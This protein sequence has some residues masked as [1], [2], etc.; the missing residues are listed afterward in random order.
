MPKKK[1]TGGSKNDAGKLRYDLIP[2][3]ALAALAFVYTIG[4]DKYED[5]N[6]EKGISFGRLIA[7]QERHVNNFKAGQNIDPKDGQHHQ[8]S[9][10]WTALAMIAFQMRGRHDLD[11][12][13]G[14]LL[15]TYE[16]EEFLEEMKA[17][18]EDV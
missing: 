11:D 5:R 17:L 6:W 7:A 2:P 18:D 10:A 15:T 8:A 13:P 1:E 3:D 16:L 14:P 12:R 9:V 4:A